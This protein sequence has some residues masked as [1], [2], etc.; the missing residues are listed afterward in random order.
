[1]KRRLFGALLG[2][3]LSAGVVGA[4]ELK[5]MKLESP[6]LSRGASLMKALSLRQ[7]VREYADKTITKRDLSDLLWAADGMNR[8][9]EQKLTAP[10]AMNQ[11]EIRLYVILPE[12]TYRYQASD[13]TLY[14]V[15]AGDYRQPIRGNMPALNIVIATEGNEKWAETDS[16]YVSQNIYLFC[17]ANGMGTVVCGRWN[18]E[19]V[20]EACDFP[21]GVVPRLVHMVGYLK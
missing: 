10:T 15:K 9:K 4:G 16:G 12:G 14:P 3:T 8:P 5:P 2:L 1:M 13:H 20:N 11:Q 7:T 19:A 17:A 6:D 18:E 21:Q